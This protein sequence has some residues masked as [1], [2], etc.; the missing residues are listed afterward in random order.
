MQLYKL[1]NKE[2][3]TLVILFFFLC[4]PE[5]SFSEIPARHYHV[6]MC[7]FSVLISFHYLQYV[8]KNYVSSNR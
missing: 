1:K 8:T 7:L 6:E 2:R 5:T 3:E 4:L